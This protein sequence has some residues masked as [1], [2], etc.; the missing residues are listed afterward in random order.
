M[1]DL[2]ENDLLNPKIRPI[3]NFNFPPFKGGF[4]VVVQ[5]EFGGIYFD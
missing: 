2:I 5:G 1:L 4:R 3:R